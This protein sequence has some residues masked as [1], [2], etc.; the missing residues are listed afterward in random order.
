MI[1]GP[2]VNLANFDGNSWDSSEVVHHVFP[3]AL[4][5]MLHPLLLFY[6]LHQ[7]RAQLQ[8]HFGVEVH[9]SFGFL[10]MEEEFFLVTPWLL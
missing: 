4:D 1:T 10:V 7:S 8:V 5:E 3:N 2:C 9:Q 6:L